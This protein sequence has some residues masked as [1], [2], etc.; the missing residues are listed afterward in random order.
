MQVVFKNEYDIL[1]I[2]NMSSGK[3]T[4]QV[5]LCWEDAWQNS[6]HSEATEEFVLLEDNYELSMHI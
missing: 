2:D 1:W 6:V 5:L 4:D 3:W